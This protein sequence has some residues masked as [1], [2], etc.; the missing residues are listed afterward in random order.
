MRRG[1]GLGEVEEDKGGGEVVLSAADGSAA[2]GLSLSPVEL[3][4]AGGDFSEYGKQ[5]QCL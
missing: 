5:V 3:E 4:G 2:D 1:R